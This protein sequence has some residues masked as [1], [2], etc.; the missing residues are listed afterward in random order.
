[1]HTL[2]YVFTASGTTYTSPTFGEIGRVTYDDE[3]GWI[4]HPAEGK[5]KAI[6]TSFFRRFDFVDME[7]AGTA[8]VLIATQMEGA[9][10]ATAHAVAMQQAAESLDAELFQR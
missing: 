9:A 3:R 2:E 7:A 5:P 1:M 4:I 8:M 10:K 6:A